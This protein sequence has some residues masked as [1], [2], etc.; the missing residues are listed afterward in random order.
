MPG[1]E[2]KAKVAQE[3]LETTRRIAAAVDEDDWSHVHRLLE[4]RQHLMDEIDRIDA[5]GSASGGAHG[6]A[7]TPP[8]F[9][10]PEE[11]G[12]HGASLRN[13]FLQ[14]AELDARILEKVI[15]MQKKVRE[16]LGKL[17]RTRRSLCAYRER[18][19]RGS[20]FMDVTR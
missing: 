6:S 17:R 8:P 19:G 15:L 11:K 2:Q 18:E 3:L 7:S 13:A 4:E 14:A 1:G 10:G 9:L 12:G 5:A 16:E 20:R